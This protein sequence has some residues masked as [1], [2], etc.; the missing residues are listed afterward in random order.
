M[1][2]NKEHAAGFIAFVTKNVRRTLCKERENVSTTAMNTVLWTAMNVCFTTGSLNRTFWV[3]QRSIAT[4][5][6]RSERWIYEIM[7]Q[8]QEAGYIQKITQKV[9][10]PG[11]FGPNVF[12]IGKRL[13]ALFFTFVKS[14]P[15]TYAQYLAKKRDVVYSRKQT[16]DLNQKKGYKEVSLSSSSPPFSFIP[17]FKGLIKSLG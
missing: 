17:N 5:A 10:K 3:C 13:M 2:L 12:K 14:N 4:R 8:L 11:D 6:H 7:Q 1:R 15:H 16:S 9:Y